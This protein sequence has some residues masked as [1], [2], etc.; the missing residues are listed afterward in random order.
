MDEK[1]I[2]QLPDKIREFIDSCM[3]KPHPKSY[4]IAVLHKVQEHF[5]YL[6]DPILDEVAYRMQIPTANVSGTATFYHF[7]RQQPKGKYAISVCLG[8]ACFVNGADEVLIAFQDELG[9]QLGETTTDG[10]FSIE[11]SRCIGV[12]A[13]APVVLVNEQVYSNVT[14]QQVP[15][16]LNSVRAAR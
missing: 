7:F 10:Q 5:G 3:E 15:E 12:C 13:L 16:I 9:I 1:Q 14:P 4:L 2:V 8:T 11:S 6:A